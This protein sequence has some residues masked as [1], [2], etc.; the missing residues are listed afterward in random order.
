M[1]PSRS[2]KP[3]VAQLL[4]NLPI[5]CGARRFNSVFTRAR[6]WSLFWANWI[7]FIPPHPISLR[8][9]Y[10]FS[11]DRGGSVALTTWHPLSAKVGTNFANKRR[12][13]VR[14]VRLRTKGHG[15]YKSY[16][17]NRPWGPIGLWDVEVPTFSGQSAHRWRWGCKPYAPATL[18]PQEYPGTPLCQRL[19]RPYS[20]S[21]VGKIT[22]IEK[23]NSR[24]SGL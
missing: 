19:S 13:L 7:Q 22:S 8:Y 17:C 24:P 16:P 6:H 11:Y 10:K 5:F 4:K 20:H 18:Y 9:W 15:V 2:Y 23:S 12:S 14:I 21:A 1:K 3:T